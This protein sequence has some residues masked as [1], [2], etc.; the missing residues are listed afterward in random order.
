ML[1]SNLEFTENGIY[2]KGDLQVLAAPHFHAVVVA[3]HFE[4]V[5]SVGGKQT[6]GHSGRRIRIHGR[7]LLV[8]QPLGYLAPREEQRPGED[9]EAVG[10]V[11][12]VGHVLVVDVVDDGT[13]DGR[14]FVLDALEERLE[15]ALVGL[16][17]R[18]EEDEHVAL[19][20]A[21]APV[22]GRDQAEPPGRAQD[23][24]NVAEVRL[25]VLVERLAELGQVRLVV[26]QDDLLEKVA[27]RAVDHTVHAAQHGRPALVLEREYDTRR[28]QVIII[29]SLFASFLCVAI[30]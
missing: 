27:R 18:V 12:R 20:L 1:I 22:L 24:H 8:G 14:A 29:L 26:D 28:R 9:A 5:A 17:V 16:D 4:K 15:P 11:G 10:S 2:S 23:A 21:S 3:A 7:L 13:E 25:A 19:G 30:G 6:A